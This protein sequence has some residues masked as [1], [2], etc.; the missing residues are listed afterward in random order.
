MADTIEIRLLENDLIV[1]RGFGAALYRLSYFADLSSYHYN[2]KRDTLHC[3]QIMLDPCHKRLRF[4]AVDGQHLGLIYLHITDEQVERLSAMP[5]EGLL[6]EAS[7]IMDLAQS[8]AYQEHE[9]LRPLALGH[10]TC[11]PCELPQWY[12]A[13]GVPPNGSSYHATD[14]YP[15]PFPSV[16]DLLPGD[17]VHD[18][19]IIPSCFNPHLLGSAINLCKSV[20][21]SEAGM[22]IRTSGIKGPLRVDVRSGLFD[23][24]ALVMPMD[25]QFPPVE[26]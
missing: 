18:E 17:D 26:L 20:P 11:E 14:A 3:V 25:Q 13:E 6:F 9:D 23:V 10:N 15:H 4:T 1:E 8:L 12:I 7:D 22:M 24:V 16:T 5:A 21:M 2:S 19:D